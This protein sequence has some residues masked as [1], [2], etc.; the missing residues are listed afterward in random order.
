MWLSNH[1]ANP[2]VDLTRRLGNTEV[3]PRQP[4]EGHFCGE[5]IAVGSLS[6]FLVLSIYPFWL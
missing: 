2:R 6:T 4:H 5:C 1:V 3:Q